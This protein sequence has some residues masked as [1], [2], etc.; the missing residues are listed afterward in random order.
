MFDLWLDISF[1]RCMTPP[2]NITCF[3]LY[4][5]DIHSQNILIFDSDTSCSS[6]VLSI[7]SFLVPTEHPLVIVDNLMWEHNHPLRTRN[8]RDQATFISL[9]REAER[10]KVKGDLPLSHAKEVCTICLRVDLLLTSDFVTVILFQ[11]RSDTI[12]TIDNRAQRIS[13]HNRCLT[14]VITTATMAMASVSPPTVTFRW[15]HYIVF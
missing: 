1:L 9:I 4:P 11:T 14:L 2:L 13:D 15:R 10:K 7:G 8:V 12:G 6:L 5:G 3:R